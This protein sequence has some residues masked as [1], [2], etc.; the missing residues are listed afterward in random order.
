MNTLALISSEGIVNSLVW[1]ICMGIVFY[2]LWWLI[3]YVGLPEPFAKVAN[4]LLAVAAVIILINIV[5][6]FA[7]H[8]LWRW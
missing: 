1:L 7:G 4:V 8:P 3:R 6:G 5:M 2:L